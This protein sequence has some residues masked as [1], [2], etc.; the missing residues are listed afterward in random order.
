MESNYS[1]MQYQQIFA[2]SPKY[3]QIWHGIFCIYNWFSHRLQRSLGLTKCCVRK[4]AK[5]LKNELHSE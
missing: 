2:R 4:I 5:Q 3:V 1:R